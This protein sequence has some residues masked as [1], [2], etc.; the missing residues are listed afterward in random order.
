MMK[1]KFSLFVSHKRK[2]LQ[3]FGGEKVKSPNL[4]PRII[5][6]I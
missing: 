6:I 2:T 1:D 5:W 3:D 4:A